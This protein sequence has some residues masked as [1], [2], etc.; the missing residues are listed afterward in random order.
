M[1]VQ[2]AGAVQRGRS[3]AWERLQGVAKN[4]GLQIFKKAA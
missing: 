4:A 1:S 3:G 2:C